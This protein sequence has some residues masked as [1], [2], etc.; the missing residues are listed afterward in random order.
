MLFFNPAETRDMPKMSFLSVR[1]LDGV[2]LFDLM[3]PSTLLAHQESSAMT[4]SVADSFNYCN[5]REK[6]SGVIDSL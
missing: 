5:T 3:T 6:N 2:V 4:L 1:V